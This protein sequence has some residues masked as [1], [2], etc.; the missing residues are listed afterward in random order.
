MRPEWL[1]DELVLNG[2]NIKDDY[3]KLFVVFERDFI[4]A[5][6]IIVEGES[7]VWDCRINRAVA[8][9]IYPYGFTHLV[10]KTIS[11]HQKMRIFDPYRAKK[12]PWVRAVLTN[13][14][15]SSVT[16][17]VVDQPD[18]QKIVRKIYL[19]LEE[20]SFVVILKNDNLGKIILTAY[21]VDHFGDKSLQR[22]KA[23]G[24]PLF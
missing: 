18:K 22:L 8:D 15:D 1:P 20:C 9:G 4:N 11:S 14:R 16:S 24:T 10:T 19:W 21:D 6:Q 17:F 7:V 23:R 12:L 5:K 13:Y 2:N 3:A